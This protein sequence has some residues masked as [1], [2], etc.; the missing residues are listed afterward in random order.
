MLRETVVRATTRALALV[1]HAC[2]VATALLTRS[3]PSELRVPKNNEYAD[4]CGP[5][6]TRR[7][8]VGAV[9]ATPQA[10]KAPSKV[11]LGRGS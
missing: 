6:P 5:P 1:A 4:V 8:T 9:G 7:T 10:A 3:S 2:S 11:A